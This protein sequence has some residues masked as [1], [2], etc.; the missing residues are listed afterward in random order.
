MEYHPELGTG[1]RAVQLGLLGWEYVR[2]HPEIAA[3]IIGGPAR[4]AESTS[5]R[6]AS[7]I[8]SSAPL[9]ARESQLLD[10][11]NGA[12]SQNGLQSV[13]LDG[14][15]RN[16]ALSR[17]QDMVERDYFAHTAPDGT[18]YFTMLQN[19]NIQYSYAGEIIA[20]N[21]YEDKDTSAQAYEGFMNSVHHRDIILNGRYTLAGVGEATNARG[22]HYFTVV[23]LVR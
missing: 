17:S 1:G 10:L 20:N 23:F 5:A 7:P 11:I 3:R 12:R 9:T 8:G 21:N 14:Q 6:S 13:S 18:T 22:F 16:I 2:A 15:L 19:A 4:A